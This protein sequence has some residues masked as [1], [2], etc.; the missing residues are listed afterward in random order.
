MKCHI[1]ICVLTSFILCMKISAHNIINIGYKATNLL[2]PQNQRW[3]DG[4]G[5]FWWGVWLVCPVH[6]SVFTVRVPCSISVNKI[7]SSLHSH[8]SKMALTQIFRPDIYLLNFDSPY[9]SFLPA[10]FTCFCFS[11][12]KNIFILCLF[13]RKY[14]K[15]SIRNIRIKLIYASLPQLNWLNFVL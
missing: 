15:R 4:G 2:T 3:C 11:C 8:R 5:G 13:N 14:Q 1:H 10:R 12:K 6:C 9:F 7:S